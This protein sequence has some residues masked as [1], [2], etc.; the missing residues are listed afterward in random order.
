M[1][2]PDGLQGAVGGRARLGTPPRAHQH[3]AEIR[4]HDGVC[5]VK[6]NRFAK[7]GFRF[8]IVS[9]FAEHVAK[10]AQHLQMSRRQC[11]GLPQYDLGLLGAPQ[12]AQHAAER[13]Q[14]LDRS[15]AKL[16]RFAQALRRRLI[17]LELALA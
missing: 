10:D 6:R 7:T 15:G 14:R 8:G 1:D 13:R 3:I 16:Q 5:R 17:L 4:K 11:E 9:E 12:Q 2:R